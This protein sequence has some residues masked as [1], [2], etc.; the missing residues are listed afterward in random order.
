MTGPLRILVLGG[1]RFVGPRLVEQLC[2][3]GAEVTVFHR[4]PP[5][6]RG[7]RT[8]IGDRDLEDDLASAFATCPAVVMDL[9]LYTGNQAQRII[10]HIRS[11]HCRYVAVSSAVVYANDSPPPWTESA[12]IEAASIWGAY[13]R[14]KEEADRLL[15]EA[16]LEH[17]LLL[18]PCYFVGPRDPAHRCSSLFGRAASGEDLLVPGDGSAI[19]QLIDVDDMASVLL[20][21]I[22]TTTCGVVN[23]G[24]S[25]PL[26]V[27]D[28]TR[29]CAYHVTEA[30]RLRYVG[31]AEPDGLDTAHWPFPNT[32]LYVSDERYRSTFRH[33]CRDAAAVIRR[34]FLW[35]QAQR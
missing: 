30:P 23:V 25:P 7:V 12:R 5:S 8:I 22:G 4:S 28:F 20:E 3:S 13:G 21:A 16:N 6:Q 17:A 2:A 31:E 32:S 9:S 33:R 14:G 11:A 35:W 27:A 18:R 29:M 19:M 34:A 15:G 24:G 26:S 1:N 10:P